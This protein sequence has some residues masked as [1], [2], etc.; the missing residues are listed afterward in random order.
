M[1]ATEK[2]RDR[3]SGARLRVARAFKGLTQTK[4][5]SEV[6]ITH[7]FIAGA[8]NNRKEPS[9]ILAQAFGEALGFEAEF[10]YGPPLD[11]FKE[12]ECNFRSWRTTPVSARTQAMAYGTLLGELL[13][14][15][16]DKVTLPPENIPRIDA[17]NPEEIERAAERCRMQWG[18][19][20]DVP[21]LSMVRATESRAGVPVA[22]FQG[23]AEKVDAFSRVGNPSLVVLNNKAA[24]RCRYDLAHECGHLV[25]HHGRQTGTPE[26]EAEANHFAAAFLLPRTGFVR[27]FPRTTYAVGDALFRLKDRW[28]VSIAALIRRASEL[29]L[30]DAIQYRRLYKHLSARGWLRHEPH[31]FEHEKP[32]VIP[33]ILDALREHHGVTPIALAGLLHWKPKTLETITGVETEQQDKPAH[34]FKA[35]VLKFGPTFR[36]TADREKRREC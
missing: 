25:L 36:S 4:L 23:I 32:E 35:N 26:T 6:G 2:N 5:A 27:E 11:E 15:A 18:L 13:A 29:S 10:F 12:A 3:F 7:Q 17:A 33:L 30:I 1:A 19:G 21:I 16:S 22:E 28:R 34:K 14:Y 8:E 31:E 20:L 24:S 9:G